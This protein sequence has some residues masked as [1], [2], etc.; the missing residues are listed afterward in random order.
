MLPPALST[1]LAAVVWALFA[2]L[3]S[4]SPARADEPTVE[5]PQVPGPTLIPPQVQ[6]FPE[7]PYPLGIDR[8]AQNVVVELILDEAGL[9]T[10]VQVLSGEEPFAGL[11]LEAAWQSRFTP[12]TEGGTPVPVQIPMTWEFPEP[13]VNVTGV[14]RRRGDRHP[15]SNVVLVVGDRATTT[16]ADGRFQLRNVAPG[17]HAIRI[18]DPTIRLPDTLV[19]LEPGEQIDL[20]LWVLEEAWT[21]E[22]VGVYR[23]TRGPAL[24]RTLTHEDIA[25]SP[26]A[27]GD[28]VRALQNVPAVSRTP[29]DTGWLL[30]RGGNPDDTGLFLDGVRIPLL[31]HLGGF[32]SVLHPE[33]IEALHFYP[34][35]PPARNSRAISGAAA[36]ESRRMAGDARAMAGVNT[37]WAH[38][39]AEFPLG[40]KAGLAASV[41]RSY[42]DAVLA[43]AI[44]EEE[45]RIAP[46]FWDAQVRV[47]TPHY[48]LLAAGIS[49]SADAPV[50]GGDTA[51]FTQRALQIQ[52]RVEGETAVGHW[53]VLPWMVFHTQDVQAPLRREHIVDLFP[54][55]RL[56]LDS[57][58]WPRT[59]LLAGVEA[60]RH[61]YRIER[62]SDRRSAPFGHVDPYAEV[63]FGDRVR[64][65]LGLRLDTLLVSGQIPRVGFS[66]RGDLRWQVSPKWALVAEGSRLHQP[67]PSVYLV[68]FPDGPYLQLEHS[69][70]ATAGLRWASGPLAVDLDAWARQTENLTGVEADGSLGQFEG[71]AYGVE[72][73]WRGVWSRTRLQFLYQFTRSRIREEPGDWFGPTLYDQPHRVNA[74]AMH[75]LPGDWS[76]AARWRISSGFPVGEGTLAFDILTQ[77]EVEVEVTRGDRTA[78]YHALDIRVAKQFTWKAWRLDATLDMQNVYGRRVP[79]PAI[80]GIDETIIAYGFGLPFLPI[81][82]IEAV[83]WP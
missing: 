62:D 68:G 28:P 18:P 22:A 23:R 73:A 7:V 26:G 31:Y 81:F 8:G 37:A 21:H 25:A 52:G 64:A 15:V 50:A 17:D 49:D 33:M 53:S 72:T 69:T 74:V 77:Q 42:L 76:L 2:I 70:G 48:G 83:F 45:S 66:P 1:A 71:I 19:S 65:R 60:E 44:G 30:V 47:D 57:E 4:A 43:A 80:N 14:V 56:E 36:L 63:A 40:E 12:A 5:P 27:M 41:R 16:D 79:E 54:G 32:T 6:V 51:V 55:L 3:G 11:V 24:R 67:P 46:R 29:L 9:P 78:P 59:R 35:A 75:R 10:R 39:F 38:A 34:G 20:D 82:G 13:P 61:D 58:P